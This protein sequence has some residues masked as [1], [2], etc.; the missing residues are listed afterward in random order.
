MFL[1]KSIFSRLSNSRRRPFLFAASSPALV[2]P[3]GFLAPAAGL[4]AAFFVVRVGDE[5][6]EEPSEEVEAARLRPRRDVLTLLLLLL[7]PF[8]LGSFGSEFSFLKE[9]KDAINF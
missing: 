3:A 8:I 4:S 1:P 2:A 9:K 5:A 6:A 7:S